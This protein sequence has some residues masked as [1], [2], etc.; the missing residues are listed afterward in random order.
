MNKKEIKKKSIIA[1]CSIFIISCLIFSLDIFQMGTLGDYYFVLDGKV[2]QKLHLSITNR[3]TL[4]TYAENEMTIINVITANWQHAV[5][6]IRDEY[7]NPLYDEE[8]H[9]ITENMINLI[10]Y[11]NGQKRVIQFVY[12]DC[13]LTDLYKNSDFELYRTFIKERRK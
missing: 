11:D 5:T 7:K 12:R 1:V 13:T 4:T 10:Y 2:T 9:N 3:A 8:G 6:F